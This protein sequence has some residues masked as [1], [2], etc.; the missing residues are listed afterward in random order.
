L[1]RGIAVYLVSQGMWGWAK[2]HG[3]GRPGQ[4]C[5]AGINPTPT[6]HTRRPRAGFRKEQLRFEKICLCTS[7]VSWRQ[8]LAN[9]AKWSYMDQT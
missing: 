5:E 3:S 2:K 1:E 9:A 4:G 6:G 7:G 8:M